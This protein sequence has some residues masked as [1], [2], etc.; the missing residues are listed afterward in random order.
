VVVV[1]YIRRR[2][3]M[4]SRPKIPF[5]RLTF[6][7]LLLPGAAVVMAGVA[8]VPAPALAQPSAAPSPSSRAGGL[9]AQAPAA[10]PS[11]APGMKPP[12]MLAPL[13]GPR[14]PAEIAPAIDAAGLEHVTFDEAVARALARNP[15]IGEAV[16]EVH[17]FHALMEQVRANS[18]PTLNG[19]ATYTRLDH[20]RLIG[21]IVAQPAGALSMNVT[22]NA[23][24]LFPRAWLTWSEA[25]DEV[26]V[27][28]ANEKDVRRTI[29]VSTGRAYL[30]ILTQ[31]RLLE[32]ARTARDNAKAHYEFTR[33]QRIG[34]V[35]NRLDEV[36]AAQEFTTEEVNVQNQAI[37]LVR[38]R[39]ALGVFLATAGPVDA[40]TED[41]PTQM[42]TLNDALNGAEKIRP[43][44]LARDEATRAADR[45]VRHAWGDYMPYLN[46]IAFPFYQSPPTST[47]PHTGWEAELVLTVPFYDGGLR[48]GQQHQRQAFA[49]EAR[50]TAE[51]TLRQARSDV[52]VAFEEI[53]R[54]DIALDQAAQSAAFA[55]RALELA[56][57]AYSAGATTNLEVI[58]AERQARDAESQYAIAEDAARQARLDLLAASGHFP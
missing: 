2:L 42:P 35:G 38:A 56:N 28:R 54:A 31:R 36:R 9:T 4:S 14:P 25:S 47:I 53:Q 45:T 11:A 46:L 52:R 40:A 29:A 15:S 58:D 17:R 49:E 22:L 23:P 20:D 55:K 51:A 57:I 50:L 24:L 7:A 13:E 16:E 27:A 41:S 6:H 5:G 19:Y 18:L 8:A 30:A 33:A 26:D 44:V 3:T 48:Y 10:P 43:D 1:A 34:G 12:P 39:E 21:T 37:A 32:T